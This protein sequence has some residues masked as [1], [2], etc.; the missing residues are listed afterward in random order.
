MTHLFSV[1]CLLKFLN[2]CLFKLF[3]LC[4]TIA[5]DDVFLMTK[6]HQLYSNTSFLDWLTHAQIHQNV[7]SSLFLQQHQH[8]VPGLTDACTDS[9]GRPLVAVPT[10]AP[11]RRSWIDWRM[12]RFTRK[13][14]RSCSYISTNTSFLDWLTHAQIH[15]NVLSSLFLHQHQHVVPGLTD[16]CT[17]SPVRPLVAVPTTAPTRRSWIDWRMHRFTSTS[18]RRCSYNS[19][20]TSFLDW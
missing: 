14:S 9:T 18:S 15:Q 4:Q 6:L 3:L 5:S 20:N 8:V 7:L 19:T 17:D 1:K 16:A 11:T 13:S 2:S 10:T 12:H